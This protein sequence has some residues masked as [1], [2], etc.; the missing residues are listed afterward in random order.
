MISRSELEAYRDK[1]IKARADGI[2]R[3]SY[4]SAVSS[5]EVELNGDA[6]LAAALADVER[7]LRDMSGGAPRI[8]NLQGSKGY[9]A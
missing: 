6:E 2:R 8:T 1:L 9:Q 3:S 7:R 4:Q 5:S